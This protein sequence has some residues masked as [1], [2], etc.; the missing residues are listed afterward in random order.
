MQRQKNK[1]GT[2]MRDLNKKGTEKEGGTEM[3]VFTEAPRSVQQAPTPAA[4]QP[5]PPTQEH[6]PRAEKKSPSPPPPQVFKIY[7]CHT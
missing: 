2:K 6:Q 5:P 1:K 3:D 4:A 7:I